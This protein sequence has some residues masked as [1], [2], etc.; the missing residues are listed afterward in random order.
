[1]LSCGGGAESVLTGCRRAHGDVPVP[2]NAREC[3]GDLVDQRRREVGQITHGADVREVETVGR[4]LV[5]GGRHHEPR[6][7]RQTRLKEPAKCHSGFLEGP[8]GRIMALTDETEQEM[9][10]ADIVV[11]Q[12]QGLG[13][14]SVQALPECHAHRARPRGGCRLGARVRRVL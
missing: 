8:R 10:R 13:E 9:L 4:L 1:M 3:S 7:Y 14:R 5:R 11:P 12:R 2:G 6:W